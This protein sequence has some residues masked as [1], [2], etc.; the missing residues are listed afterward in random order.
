MTWRGLISSV[1]H[2]LLI[3]GAAGILAGLAVN[4]FGPSSA[5]ESGPRVVGTAVTAGAESPT[6]HAQSVDVSDPGRAMAVVGAVAAFVGGIAY[7]VSHNDNG[8]AGNL[9]RF[10]IATGR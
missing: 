10:H 8:A 6:V 2:M 7:A 1:A 9:R 3:L 4:Q 5:D